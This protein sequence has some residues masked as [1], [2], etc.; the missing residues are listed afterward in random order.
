[1]KRLIKSNPEKRKRLII[2]DFHGN[3]YWIAVDVGVILW[4]STDCCSG[5]HREKV[6]SK[7]LIARAWKNV[8]L[9][10]GEVKQQ[11]CHLIGVTKKKRVK[12]NDANWC[13]LVNNDDCCD[14]N[15]DEG[16]DGNNVDNN[17]LINPLLISIEP[18]TNSVSNAIPEVIS[19][20]P[21]SL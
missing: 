3:S 6:G 1:M 11:K 18:I 12:M 2:F 7:K 19:I 9:R 16:Y 20:F 8:I 5:W 14:D 21:E 4:W 15:G 17:T 10:L 13:I